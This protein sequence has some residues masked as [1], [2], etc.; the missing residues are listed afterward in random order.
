MEKEGIDL[1]YYYGGKTNKQTK[2]KQ[3]NKQKREDMS[4]VNVA[5]LSR[6]NNDNIKSILKPVPFKKKSDMFPLF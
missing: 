6:C 3:T 4:V 1:A 5:V 2:Q